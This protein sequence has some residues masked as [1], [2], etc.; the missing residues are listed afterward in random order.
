VATFNVNDRTR[1]SSYF[2]EFLQ[3]IDLDIICLQE[4]SQEL[5]GQLARGLGPQYKCVYAYSDFCGNAI[6]TR[7]PI[8]RSWTV[9]MDAIISFSE[10]RSAAL[11]VLCLDL[12]SAEGSRTQVNGFYCLWRQCAKLTYMYPLHCITLLLLLPLAR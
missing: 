1:N 12:T 9:Q 3:N 2:I 4:V 8:E 7:L 5:A 10:M 11:A 6:L